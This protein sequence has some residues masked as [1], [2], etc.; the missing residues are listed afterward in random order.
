MSSLRNLVLG[1]LSDTSGMEFSGCERLPTKVF[2]AKAVVVK[3]GS[4]SALRTCVYKP[5][6]RGAYVI[7]VMVEK[8]SALGTGVCKWLWRVLVEA[9]KYSGHW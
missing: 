7:T 1:V 4:W 3:T 6:L 8:G 9:S 5:L 2:L